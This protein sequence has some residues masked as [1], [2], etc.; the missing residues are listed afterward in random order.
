MFTQYIYNDGKAL[1]VDDKKK[2]SLVDYYDNLD[3]VLVKEN[4]IEKIESEIVKVKNEINSI[5]KR[6]IPAVWLGVLFLSLLPML[7]SST[8]FKG[9]DEVMT[10]FGF[11]INENVLPGC[12]V[13]SFV[14]V[15]S[16]VLAVSETIFI[17]MS[18]RDKHARKLQ[19]SVLEQRLKEEKNM[20]EELK[21]DKSN[22]EKQNDF[23]LTFVNDKKAL[24]DLKKYLQTFY[25]LGFSEDKYYKRYQKN[26]LSKCFNSDEIEIVSNYFEDNK[27]FDEVYAEIEP[28][29]LKTI[30][31]WNAAWGG[32]TEE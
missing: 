18:R 3:D 25:E 32:Y 23:Y 4:L 7:I 28:D 31:E 10:I 27:D 26:K 20:L 17:N 9:A 11:M 29:A 19:L 24:S 8:L 6:S 22:T 13:S 15:I 30:A 21:L 14:F 12:I 1:I 16:L 2:Q 5:K